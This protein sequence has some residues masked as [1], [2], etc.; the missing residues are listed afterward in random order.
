MQQA[1]NNSKEGDW[2]FSIIESDVPL[3][4]QFVSEQFWIDSLNSFN[5]GYNCHPRAGSYIP[6]IGCGKKSIIDE[7]ES[8]V[9]EMI[10][11]ILDGKPYRAI[12]KIYG[13][14]IGFL[15]NLKHKD[16]RLINFFEDKAK[17]SLENKRLAQYKKERKK[18][19]KRI[20]LKLLSLGYNYSYIADRLSVSTGYISYV[21]K[22]ASG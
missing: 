3:I 9:E 5:A 22:C 17:L 4:N 11:L 1:W 12:S 19:L 8:D 16:L 10:I 18:K 15:S 2:K 13:V 14:S 20:V 21:N 6:K 7:R